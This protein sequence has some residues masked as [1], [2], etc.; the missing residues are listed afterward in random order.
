MYRNSSLS[1]PGGFHTQVS[2]PVVFVT[3][4]R[5]EQ[6]LSTQL[7][8]ARLTHQKERKDSKD[9]QGYRACGLLQLQKALLKVHPYFQF[10]LAVI[11]S[12]LT[13]PSR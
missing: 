3:Y 6:T 1:P 4:N 5:V 11:S 9:M 8:S 7:Y 10:L 12:S 13:N 2:A